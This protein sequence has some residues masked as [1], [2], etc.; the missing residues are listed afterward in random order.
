M[1]YDA[2][3]YVPDE[4]D[5][6]LTIETERLV[7]KV[8]DNTGL[9][10]PAD[11]EAKSHYARYPMHRLLPYSHHLGYHGLRTLYDRSEK[12]NLV[13]PTASWLNLQTV[14]F[15]GLANDPVDERAWA[16]VGRGWPM[17]LEPKGRGA[18]LT[19][20]PLPQTQFR[21]TIE[22][23]PAEP[24]GID[25]SMRFVFHRRPDTGPCRFHAT[26]PCYMNAYDD[27]RFFYP[28]GASPDQWAWAGLGEK[29]D[30][31]LGETVGYRHQHRGY[32]VEEQA[33]PVGYGLI[34]E[35]ALILM[36]NDPRV[37]FFVVNGGGHFALSPV[38]NP[39]WD[40]RW[41]VED[42]PLDTP[43]GIDGRLIYTA[44]QGEDEVLQRYREWAGG[45]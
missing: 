5:P 38:Q 23:Q 41:V 24:D 2:L 10:L 43:V 29:P 33:L 22:F 34:G 26:W 20:D 9:S 31:I 36:F 40:F 7:A 27:V 4:E 45:R 6:S 11:P 32:N 13:V 19:V 44:F 12:R 16:G 28:K 39:A 25:F 42:Y 37:K 14:E 18:L 1:Q 3:R 17:R 35:R 30:F 21:Y 8:I 15:A